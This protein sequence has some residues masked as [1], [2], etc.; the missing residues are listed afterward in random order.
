MVIAL[1]RGVDVREKRLK[2]WKPLPKPV[3]RSLSSSS[4]EEPVHYG[5]PV[6]CVHMS[7]PVALEGPD[8][9]LLS[10]VPTAIHNVLNKCA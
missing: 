8:A 9:L 4:C 2:G 5:P 7:V 1:F 6:L 3:L 10:S